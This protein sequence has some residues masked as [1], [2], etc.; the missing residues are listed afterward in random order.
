[1][2]S[3]TDVKQVTAT[4]HFSTSATAPELDFIAAKFMALEARLAGLEAKNE[5]LEG[6]LLIPHP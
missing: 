3:L 2:L 1:M 4:T 5:A 6:A